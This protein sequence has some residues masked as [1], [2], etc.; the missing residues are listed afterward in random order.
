MGR[1]SFGKIFNGIN[2]K[3][4]QEVA[5]KL[6]S[7]NSDE[8]KINHESCLYKDYENFDAFP[9]IYYF[10]GIDKVCIQS[11][12]GPNLETLFDFCDR[13]FD[14]ITISNIGI[15]L[16]NSIEQ[17][18]KYGFLHRDIKPKNIAWI[19]F[20]DYQSILKNNLILIDFGLVGSYVTKE[21]RHFSKITKEGRV[22]TQ[23]FSSI[24]ASKG[25]TLSRKD[26]LEN[27]FFCLVYFFKGILPW[28]PKSKLTKINKI[29]FE[30][31][32]N[33]DSRNRNY[34]Q[35]NIS[36]NNTRT[37][38]EIKENIPVYTLCNG[39]PNEY[40]FIYSYIKNLSFTE[41]PDYNIIRLLLKNAILSTNNSKTNA[42]T[43]KFIWERKIKNLLSSKNDITTNIKRIK[44]TL[45]QGYP[46]QLERLQDLFS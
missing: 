16:I 22:G 46:I 12:L 39:M 4:K 9:K 10:S 26:D 15:E 19:N 40:K 20:S 28:D 3:I 32:H 30:N 21:N 25:L 8:K 14:I 38:L 35:K 18:H 2:K 27:I 11:L 37:I 34:K 33:I 23:Y 44:E 5:V 17:L 43:Y 7:N 29:L 13:K 6:Y 42:G 31:T 45:F 24:N 1:G 36:K 41:T